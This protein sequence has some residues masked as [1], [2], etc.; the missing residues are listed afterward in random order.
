LSTILAAVAPGADPSTVTLSAFDPALGA[1]Q[2]LPTLV[3]EDGRIAAQVA[4]LGVPT[5]PPAAPA[6]AP[7]DPGAAPADPG[8]A[9]T[10]PGVVPADPAL[11]PTDPGLAPAD[12]GTA[13]PGDVG[14]M[15][16]DPDG[17]ADGNAPEAGT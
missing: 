10:D 15:T 4:A 5:P 13:T 8:L 16:V 2:A 7:T 17:P 3:T 9:P 6:P 12:P 14:L 1:L 11:A